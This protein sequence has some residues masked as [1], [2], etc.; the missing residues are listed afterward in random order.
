[1][2]KII[3]IDLG[4]T[5]SCVAVME[6]GEPVVIQ[7][8][9]GGR[10]TPSIVGFTAKGDRI[11]GQPAKNQMVTNPKNTVYSVKRLIGHRFSELQGEATKLPYTVLDNGADCRVQI[12]QNGEKKQFSPQEIS[13]FILQKMKKTAEDYLGEPVTEAVITVPAYFNDAQRQATKDAGKI[14]GL[15]VKRIINEP[16][17]ASLAFGFNKDQKQDKT[18]AVYD[19]GGGTF[20]ISILELGDG[21]FEVKS[22]N[23]DTHLGGDDWDRAV[24]N[25]LIA[26]FKKDSGID[27]SNDAMAMQRLREAAENAK[28]QLSSQTSTDINLPFI[29]ADATGPKHLQKTLTR[30]QFEQMTDDLFERTKEPCRKALADAGISADKVDEVLLVGGSSRMPK[31]QEVVKSIFGKEGSR[32]VNPDEAVAVG[33]A[34]QGGVLKG[35]VKDVLLLDV[36]PLSLGIETMGGVFT[37]LIP[38]NTTIPTKKSQIF[39]TAADGQTAVSIH[40]LQGEREMAAQNRTLGNFD[41]VGI[42]AAPRGVPQ[43]EVTFD[44]DA[45]GI[46]HVSAKDLGT[47]KEQHI[48]ITS[49]SGLSEDEI[50][51]MVKDAEANAAADKEKREAVDAKNEAD[52]LIYAT[53]KSLKDLGD[54][55]SGADKQKIEDAVAALKKALESDNTSDIKAKT[56]ELKQASYKIAEEVYKQQAAQGGAG[57]QGASDAGAGA[58]AAGTDSAKSSNFDKGSA[59]DVDYEVKDDS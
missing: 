30:A 7:N 18:I 59:E 13:A 24:I 21:V 8:S 42:P 38:R 41:L 29:T 50:N 23:G 27:L 9:E 39:S 33:A 25:W 10:T 37:K 16:T 26:E 54:K 36:T 3:G 56:E 11:V 58:D 47:G 52:S 44:I 49:S 34:I 17:A 55:V 40:V 51:R 19:L 45:N 31:V 57:A 48:Q 5:N 28:I 35:D 6:N 20:D 15:D 53:E 32:A 1:M 2:S 43:I 12:E 4:T 22:T 46:V 14:A